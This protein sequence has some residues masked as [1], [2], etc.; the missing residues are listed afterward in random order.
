MQKSEEEKDALIAVTGASTQ[1]II[2]QVRQRHKDLV[3]EKSD[4]LKQ[5]QK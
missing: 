1:K 5:K 3:R 4:I 2:P